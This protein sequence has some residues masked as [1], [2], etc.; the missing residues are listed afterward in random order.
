MW[1]R[2][3]LY[4]TLGYVLDQLGAQWNT[5]GFWAVL[6]LFWASETMTRTQLLEQLQEEIEAVRRARGKHND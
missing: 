5:W 4:A 3:A 1:T 2:I 6:G